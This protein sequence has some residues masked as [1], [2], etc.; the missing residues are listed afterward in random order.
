MTY[1]LPVTIIALIIIGIVEIE[2][3]AYKEEEEF[4]RL[5]EEEL[6]HSLEEMIESHKQFEEE[7]N[8]RLE[9]IIK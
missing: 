9:K 6:R 7:I 2:R 1:L 3:R 5:L 8:K 4:N